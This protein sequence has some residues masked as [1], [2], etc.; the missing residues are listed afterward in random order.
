MAERWEDGRNIY[1]FV[2]SETGAIW[3]STVGITRQSAIERWIEQAGYDWDKWRRDGF[4]CRKA[5]IK[6]QCI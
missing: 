3:L 6:F 1:W 2:F 5:K 4:R